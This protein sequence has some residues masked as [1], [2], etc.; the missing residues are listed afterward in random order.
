MV[1]TFRRYYIDK[2]LNSN[3]FAGR[4]LDIGGK[5]K[6]KRG[7]FSISRFPHVESWEYVNIDSSTNPDYLCSA[8][9]IPVPDNNF[10]FVILTDVLE[11]LENCESVLKECHRVLKP[12]GSIIIT[13]PF[14]YPIHG[15]P[16]DYQRW[17]PSR[18][19]VELEKVQL[20]MEIIAPM[21]GLFAVLFD[22]I[23]VSLGMASKNR[24]ALKN[25]IANKL[26]MPVL[27]KVFLKLDRIFEYK[28]NRITSGWY[29]KAEK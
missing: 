13:M 25:R 5:K 23:Y 16:E 7:N 11:H 10:D 20:S 21:G 18:F 14:L 9:S 19:E 4:V 3:H 26:I 22:L 17:T 2:C 15:D 28:S 8:D 24:L 12:K 27:F 1:S 29:V 6:N